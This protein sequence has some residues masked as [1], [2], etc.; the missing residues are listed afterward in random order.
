[1]TL[2]FYPSIFD[3]ITDYFSNFLSNTE[4][5]E[6]SEIYLPFVAQEMIAGAINA[7]LFAAAILAAT[8]PEVGEALR[9]FRQAQTD[10]IL[11]DPDPRQPPPG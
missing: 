3:Y 2:G 6:K 7:A 5:H 4:N 1:M 9:A 8:H 10:K 11:A